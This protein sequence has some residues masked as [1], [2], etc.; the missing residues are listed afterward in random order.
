MTSTFSTEDRTLLRAAV[1]RFVQDRYSFATR[2]D[3]LESD[4]AYSKT[5]WQEMAEL[6]LQGLLLQE[7]D[8]GAG[9][10]DEELALVMEEIGRGLLLEPYLGTAVLCAGLI[11][12][13]GT[14]EQRSR[15]LPAIAAGEWICALAHS[16]PKMGFARAPVATEAKGDGPS[17]TLTGTKSFVLDGPTAGTFLVSAAEAGGVSLFVLPRN[18]RNLTIKPWRTVDGRPA[19]E[20]LLCGVPVQE[21]DRLGAPGAAADALDALLDRATLAVGAEALGAMQCLLEQTKDYLRTRRQFGQP[22]SRFQVLQHRL[23]DMYIAIAETRALLHAGRE[24]LT[25]GREERQA[26]VSAA[27]YKVGQATRF[28]G[29]QAI[30][31]HGAIGMTDELPASHYFKRLLMIDAMF[32]NSAH[33]LARFRCA[34]RPA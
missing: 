33:H 31:M 5:V 29:E 8:G 19:A 3:V 7:E 26:A 9:G 10:S 28:V 2:R 27:K 23:V 30:Q 20:L 18:A 14:Q 6:G 15:L 1:A 4:G 13:L 12:A 21:A 34:H 24:A 22:L 25:A 17:L 16:E 11:T 32:G